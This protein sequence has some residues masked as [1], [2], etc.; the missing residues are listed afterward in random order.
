[1][2]PKIQNLG[3]AEISQRCPLLGNITGKYISMAMNSAT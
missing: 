2:V 1:M 3:I